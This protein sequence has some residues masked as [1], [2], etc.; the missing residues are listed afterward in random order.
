[1]RDKIEESLMEENKMTFASLTS[2]EPGDKVILDGGIALTVINSQKINH[3]SLDKNLTGIDENDNRVRFNIRQALSLRDF[4]QR[5]I[6]FDKKSHITEYYIY[7][8][9]GNEITFTAADEAIRAYLDLPAEN[10]G[11]GITNSEGVSLDFI[12]CRQ[13]MSEIITDFCQIEDWSHPDIY[14][15]FE[16]CQKLVQAEPMRRREE[17]EEIHTEYTQEVDQRKSLGNFNELV[18]ILQKYGSKSDT[19]MVNALFAYI[20]NLQAEISG[21]SIPAPLQ[22]FIDSN[23]QK[24]EE[25]SVT[26][27]NFLRGSV[28]KLKDEINLIKLELNEKAGQIIKE[29]KELGVSALNSVCEKLGVRQILMNLKDMLLAHAADM[30]KSIDKID[31]ARKEI[32]ETTTHAKNVMSA[33]RGSE[34]KESPELKS[35]GLLYELK[36]PCLAL[37]YLDVKYAV[38]LENTIASI[39]RIGHAAEKSERS[40]AD[41]PSVLNR[42]NSLKSIGSRC[43]QEKQRDIAL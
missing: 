41:R 25:V 14:E 5:G 12:R 26:E 10:R 11:I 13:G 8:A 17:K 31:L 36:Q 43:P 24:I 35:A 32:T 22:E 30:Q 7:S 9:D 16:K 6:Q 29:F 2:L 23:S 21:V 19:E 28:E 18:D 33:L 27:K 34:L 40:K 1:M 42:L 39:D 38:K 4:W 37:K 20:V 3:E 15:F